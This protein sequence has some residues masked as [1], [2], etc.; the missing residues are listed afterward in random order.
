MCFKNRFPLV[1]LSLAVVLGPSLSAQ[2]PEWIWHPNDGQPVANQE[3]RIF[4][5]VFILA[6]PVERAVLSVAADNHAEVTL[7]QSGVHAIHGHERATQLNV[8]AELRRGTNVIT[9]V[10][11]NDDGPA[12][13]LVQLQITPA[14]GPRQTIVSDASWQALTPPATAWDVAHLPAGGWVAARSL[15]A[16]GTGPWGD[17]F[18]VAQ[19]TPAESLVVPPGFKVE[20]IHTA[21]A[22]EGSWI[23]LAVD[24][25]GRLTISPQSDS[26]PLLRFTL[27]QRGQVR[28]IEPVPAPLHQ[29]MGMCYAFGSLYVNGHGPEGTGLYRV[30]DTNHN[31]RFEAEEVQFLKKIPGEGEHGYH[32]VLPGPD[33]RLYMMNGNHTKLPEGITP[34]SPHKNY[35]EDFLL[36]RLWDANGHAVGIMAPG[37]Q[38]LRTDPAGKQWELLLAGF[39]NAYD[40]DFSPEGEV[41]TFD[42]DMEWD[43]GLPWYRPTRILHCVQGGEYGW[44]SGSSKWP[45]YY[46]DSLPAVVDI[47]IGSPTGVKFGTHSRFPAKYQRAFFAADWS[48]GRILAVHL[49]PHGASY[50][51][52]TE[53]F[54]KGTPLNVADFEF[55]RDG[56]MYFVTGGRGTQSGLYRVSYTGK[57][58]GFF[59]RLFTREQPAV[60]RAEARAAARARALR[61]ELEALQG[62]VNPETV[63]AVWPHLGSP[64][65]FIRYAA[66]IALEWQDVQQWKDRAVQETDERTALTA[67]LALAR[68][69]GAETQPELLQALA[70]FPTATSE[71]WALEKLRILELSFIRQGRP[72]PGVAARVAE[73]L[74]AHYPAASFPLNRELSQ[75]LVYLQAPDVVAKTLALLDEAPTQEEQV[76]YLYT[77]RQVKSGWTPAQREKYFGWFGTL[78]QGS[79]PE[80]TYPRGGTY[81]VWTNQTHARQVHPP[82]LIQ[83]FKD[84]GR[85]YGDG[86]SYNKY[87]VRIRKDAIATLTSAERQQW[88][89][90][91]EINL[92]GPVWKP[93]RPRHFVKEWTLPD[94]LPALPGVAR[95]RNFAN[96]KAAFNDAQCV[97]CHR[98]ANEGGSVGPELAGVGSKYSLES[99]LESI[100]EPSKVISD[101]YQNFNIWKKDGDDVSGRIID[102]NAERVVVLPNM[103]APEVTVEVPVTEIAR[104]EPS[105]VS[106]MPNGL[107]DSLSR[108]DILDLLAY[109][110]AQGKAGAPNFKP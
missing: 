73:I 44:R 72:A 99:I 88:Q 76:Y 48:Y 14:Q 17:P 10:G 19:A 30:T 64:D 109:L 94:L 78:R 6:G 36:P 26:Q 59:S 106:A 85:D 49:Q 74:D 108:D 102:E 56:A 40:F 4:R 3:Q 35:Q 96:G 98:F 5:K 53:E 47:G 103:L 95:G 13:L 34:D 39:R 24:P 27:D 29:A 12:G 69:G 50:T 71:E 11:R 57:T 83:W 80:V 63:A 81:N 41:F 1:V 82:E 51:G 65:R 60:P 110:Q 61:H 42:S 21:A 45:E 67:L 70:R 7:N 33:G 22:D 79:H 37:G 87:L 105:K 18:K 62:K 15:G 2:T 43:W 8:T 25:Q 90:L 92:D 38:L 66:R 97:A 54:V 55:G 77:L 100:I 89:S 46:P 107:L 86:A 28:H 9:I 23:S 84:V 104:R 58:P 52:T 32:A 93:T 91:L 68:C 20:L 75:L 101:Q 31:D 16:V